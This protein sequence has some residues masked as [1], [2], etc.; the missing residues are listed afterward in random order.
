MSTGELTKGPEEVGP[1]TIWF[2]LLGGALAW[3]PHLLV[4]YSAV[5]LVC[6]T[7]WAIV[8]YA[9]AGATLLGAL[10]ATLVAWRGWRRARELTNGAP[11]I[12]QRSRFM[13]LSGLILSA[14]FVA[15]IV[16]QSL[17]IFLQHPCAA[18]GS[19]RI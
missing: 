3:I 18:A 15:V 13:T 4:S 6:E 5:P 8:L 12:A 19:L 1:F 14:F 10:A 7:G 11:L 17:P 16:A 2:G 9:T